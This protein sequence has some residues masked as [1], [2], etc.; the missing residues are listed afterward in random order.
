MRGIAVFCVL[1]ALMMGAAGLVLSAYG[2][3]KSANNSAVLRTLLLDGKTASAISAKKTAAEVKL[4]LAQQSFNQAQTRNGQKNLST[5]V[6]EVERHLDSTI[7]AE[8]GRATRHE[9]HAIERVARTVARKL[10]KRG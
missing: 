10:A 2:A 7:N 3:D 1:C 5:A 6:H 4:L 9:A 8:I